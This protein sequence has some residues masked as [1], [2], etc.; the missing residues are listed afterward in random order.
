MAHTKS[1]SS[2]VHQG[3]NVAGKRL[4][5]KVCHG[6]KVNRGVILVRQR[7]TVYYPGKNVKVCRDFT[8]MSKQPGTVSI[9]TLRGAKRGK[10][11]INVI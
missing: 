7:G 1:R 5:L 11:C 4:G 9:T 2:K 6:Q 3:V 10:K 8:L